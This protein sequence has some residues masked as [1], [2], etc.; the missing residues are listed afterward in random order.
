MTFAQDEYHHKELPALEGEP[1]RQTQEEFRQV[2]TALSGVSIRTGALEEWTS[3]HETAYNPHGKVTWKGDWAPGTYQEFDF[4]VD[5]SVAGVANKVTTDRPAPQTVGVPA[6]VYSGANPTSAISAKQL[7]VGQRYTWERDGTVSALRLYTVT[8]NSYR[9]YAVKDPLGAAIPVELVSQFTAENT[10]IQ[11]LSIDPTIVYNGTTFDLYVAMEQP[12]PSPTIWSANYNYVKPNNAGIPGVG[13]ISHANKAA[14]ELRV[15]KTD[16]DGT[17]RGAQLLALT[18]GDVVAALGMRWSLQV[19][20]IDNGTYVTL[21]VAPATQGAPT[22]VASFDFETVQA[23]PITVVIDDDPGDASGEGYWRDNPNISGRYQIDGGAWVDTEDQYSVD[24]EVQEVILSPD[25]DLLPIGG[26]GGSSGDVGPP[27]PQGEQGE[28]GI[29]GVQGPEG[30]QGIPGN[31]GSDGADGADGYTP[32]HFYVHVDCAAIT[33][34]EDGSGQALHQNAAL[35]NLVIDYLTFGTGND[36]YAYIKM[37]V[38][39]EW[40]GTSLRVKMTWATGGGSQSGNTAIMNL[41]ATVV[42]AGTD[43]SAVTFLAGLETSLTADTDTAFASQRSPSMGVHTSGSLNRD[44]MIYFRIYRKLA[45]NTMTEGLLLLGID[46]EFD[47]NAT[48]PT[49]WT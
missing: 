17:D 14:D 49:A 48:P 2:E 22:G 26:G 35:G 44:S 25:W 31:D 24:M 32:T 29:Q 20:P 47:V 42:P 15:R 18:A 8:G 11:V 16:D 38:P 4:A 23:T 5:G 1:R 40:G 27:G 39:Q 46:F 34:E 21:V 45:G 37:Q 41:A 6:P 7:T 12:D 10:G 3:D 9:V 33:V 36:D 30:S 13:D 43:L 19:A 28:Q